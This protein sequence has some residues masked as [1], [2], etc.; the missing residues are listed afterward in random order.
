MERLLSDGMVAG[1]EPDIS[2]DERTTELSPGD[3]LLLYTDGITEARKD[4]GEM[5][6]EERLLSLWA[7][8]AEDSAQRLLDA[9]YRWAK[10]FSEGHFHDDIAML[11]IT[12]E[13]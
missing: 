10:E 5:L 7:S 2:H 6:G 11:V 9:L 12:A 13:E 1:V 4:S 3:R 8:L